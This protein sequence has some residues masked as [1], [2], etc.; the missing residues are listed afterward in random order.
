M[1]QLLDI[2]S[3]I[4]AGELTLGMALVAICISLFFFFY[5]EIRILNKEHIQKYD[6][7]YAKYQDNQDRLVKQMFEAFNKNTEANT[8]LAE[9][10]R[11]L[12]LKI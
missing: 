7:I 2:L 8:R 6:E 5:R 12:S 4:S 9:A 11:D 1:S 3:K 10:V